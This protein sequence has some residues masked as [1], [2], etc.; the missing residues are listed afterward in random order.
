MFCA[1]YDKRLL[2]LFVLA[3]L[4]PRVTA[5]NQL[6]L[7]RKEKKKKKKRKKK[8]KKKQ[9]KQNERKMKKKENRKIK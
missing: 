8:R 9:R 1:S 3:I 6:Y 4:L 7:W 5:I 2:W